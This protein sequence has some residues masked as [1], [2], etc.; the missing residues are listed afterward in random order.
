MAK[1]NPNNIHSTHTFKPRHIPGQFVV[2][3]VMP[4]FQRYRYLIILGGGVT[5]QIH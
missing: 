1:Q 2:Q 5:E 3:D 4:I